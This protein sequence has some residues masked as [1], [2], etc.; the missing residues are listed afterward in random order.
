MAR[1]NIF[2]IAFCLIAMAGAVLAQD[3]PKD[4]YFHDL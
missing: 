3:K 2:S 1:Q 4:D